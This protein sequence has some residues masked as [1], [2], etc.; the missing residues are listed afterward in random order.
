M[1]KLIF[2][3]LFVLLVGGKAVQAGVIDA[4]HNETNNIACGDCHSYSLWW[5]FSP[6]A[7]DSALQETKVNALCSHCHGENGP[8]VN[9]INH[10]SSAL[11]SLH[12][13]ELGDFSN[14]CINCH[15]PHFQAQL[16][17]KQTVSNE[18]MYLV[19]ADLVAGSLSVIGEGTVASP[20][21]STFLY[22]NLI[23]N[24]SG[25]A[26]AITPWSSKTGAPGRG[27]ILALTTAEP[28][29]TYE[30]I[31]VDQEVGE[32]SVQGKVDSQYNENGGNFGLIYGQLIRDR[33]IANGNLVDVRFFNPKGGFVDT[34]TNMG[35]CQVCHTK[36][37]HFRS[38]GEIN[39]E[40]GVGKIDGYDHTAQIESN[41][42][43]CHSHRNGL[44][45]AGG[46][47]TGCGSATE[48]HGLQDSHVTHVQIG[49]L[50][51]V[52]CDE[53]HNTDNFPYFNDD[54]TIASTTACN[55]C[56]G[57]GAGAVHAKQYWESPG[58]SVRT[59]G[60]WAVVEGEASFCGSCHDD[61]PG[62]SSGNGDGDVAA[63]IMGDQITYGFY[64]TGHGKESGNYE[65]MYYQ[66]QTGS[67]NR[68]AALQVCVTCHG[69]PPLPPS[70]GDPRVTPCSFCHDIATS[71][72]NNP[73]KR[74][75]LEF[76][77]DQNN[78][79][80][81]RCHPPG[82]VAYSE[83]VLYSDSAEFEAGAH[84]VNKCTD[85]HDV[86]GVGGGAVPAMSLGGRRDLCLSCHYA[87]NSQGLPVPGPPVSGHD[88]GSVIACTK[89]HNP[90]K[91]AHGQGATGEG[92]IQCHGHD[93]GYEYSSGKFSQGRGSSFSHS[94]HTENDT[95]D[96]RGPN[97]D[98]ED[99]HDVNNFPYFQRGERTYPD[100]RLGQDVNGDGKYDLSETYVCEDCHSRSGGV[101][102]VTDPQVGAKNNWLEGIY[103]GK[104]LQAGKEMW[105]ASCHDKYPSRMGMTLY[106]PDVY[107]DNTTSGY[108]ASG[109]GRSGAIDCTHCHDP[110]SR[111]I[112]YQQTPITNMVKPGSTELANPTNYR[113]YTGK[114][115]EIPFSKE[116][117][118]QDDFALCY[119]C[120]EAELFNNNDNMT[121]N[122]RD[123]N[124][125]NYLDILAP[126]NL[127]YYHIYAM[128]TPASCVQCHDPHGTGQP[129]M[130]MPG[131]QK[132][133]GSTR[134]GEFVFLYQETDNKFYELTNSD[135]FDDPSIN[136]GFAI[137]VNPSCGVCHGD[138]YT[139]EE[140]AAGFG[141][142]PLIPSGSDWYLRDYYPIPID[143]NFDMDGD[144]IEDDRDNCA[145]IVN[146]DQ[147]DGDGDG[148]GDLCDNCLEKANADQ[149]DGDLDQIGDVC[150]SKPVC[151]KQFDPLIIDQF[152][153]Q[154]A[155]FGNDITVDS[156]GNVTMVGDTYGNLAGSQI[157]GRD[158][159]VRKYNNTGSQLWTRK[160]GTASYEYG[161]GVAV[162]AGGSSFITGKTSGDLEGQQRGLYDVFV[163]KL[164]GAGEQVWT[165]Q[166]GTSENEEGYGV[167]LDSQGS[168]Y[169]AGSTN[170]NLAEDTLGS[171]DAFLRK[172]DV[173]G[174]T[175]WTRQF[176]TAST[177]TIYKVA[178]DGNDR[179][180][181]AGTTRGGEIENSG[182]SGDAFLRQYDSDGNV[183]WT[184]Q[185]GTSTFG[186]ELRG[187]AIDL[188]NNLYVAGTTIGAL[189]GVNQGGADGYIRK[190]DAS[191]TYLW[192]Q[193]LGTNGSDLV[194]GVDVD[195]QGN[196][197]IIGETAGDLAG[198]NQGESD[199]FIGRFD[200]DGNLLWKGQFGTYYEYGS[201]S[202]ESASGI[203]IDSKDNIF[204]TGYSEGHFAGYGSNNNNSKDAFVVKGWA[205]P[206]DF[207]QDDFANID[208]NCSAVAN[209]DQ[210]DIDAD[211]IGDVCD[212]CTVADNS[213]QSDRDYDGIGDQCDLCVND[214]Y[215]DFDNDGVCA[216]LDNCPSVSNDQTDSDFD[217]IGDD[218]D[219][220]PFDE[221]NDQ[222]LDGVCGLADNCPLI[223][224][225][226]QL[227]GDG[228]TV[229]DLCDNCPAVANADQADEDG[230]MVGD[231]CDIDCTETSTW[232]WA[233]QGG[234]DA[235]DY[236]FSLQVDVSGNVYQAG[237]TYGSFNGQAYAGLQDAF[238]VKYDTSGNPLW[239][240]QFGTTKDDDVSDI[241]LDA[242][243]NVYL[244]G[245]TGG[246]LA[247]T[248]QGNNDA[249]VR[250]YDATG[251]ISWTR[252]FG[253][254]SADFGLTIAVDRVNNYVYTA[255]ITQGVMDGAH[256]GN[257]DAYIRKFD[258]D[259]NHIWTRQFG[260]SAADEPKSIAI[261]SVGNIYVV[262]NT[263][264]D[265]FGTKSPNYNADVFV[266]KY[267]ADGIQGWNDHFGN[268]SYNYGNGIAL[269]SSDNV[270]VTGDLYGNLF[271][272]SA[273]SYDAFIRKYNSGG[274]ILW[275]KQYGTSA[276][277]KCLDIALDAND[278]FYIIGNTSGYFSG[279]TSN[280]G[281]NDIF[282]SK[283]NPAGAVLWNKQYGTSGS[284]KGYA[285]SVDSNGNVYAS[286]ESSL[287]F[288]A[289]GT[290][291]THLGSSDAVVL[292][293]GQCP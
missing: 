83:P 75:R 271:G 69:I 41:C 199:L 73:V 189:S 100:Y 57:I 10:S 94:T 112:D 53:C 214:P 220:C 35:I 261:D 283:F 156:N 106:A 81:N 159:F 22:E 59:A 276:L 7:S 48:C 127:H 90:H 222:D 95:D 149:A 33:I 82:T 234:S 139:D 87:G 174:E 116:P 1:R 198:S 161:Y 226:D 246:D 206:F 184:R 37:R 195:S 38:N 190:Y 42:I 84:G 4:P 168:I 166:F 231:I 145:N 209:A 241:A 79:N 215:N 264:G 255:G 142:S 218:C 91:P 207:D 114:S 99:C 172:L 266:V 31:H 196:A 277:D 263:W 92:C 118:L 146:Q 232:T 217:G 13:T 80:C 256:Q 98:C 150:D 102:G 228:D 6:I 167:A 71:H 34:A 152:G 12:R 128:Y 221:S 55:N 180:T 131:E 155:D 250:K 273:G 268:S 289:N 20:Y 243:G 157:G 194:F 197:V 285:V 176:G 177:D 123:P 121:T 125:R 120:H 163:M 171:A 147:A 188:N 30:V 25:W 51:G 54:Q 65:P 17:W 240:R 62:N 49:G 15:D 64:I 186:E 252:Q 236:G 144:T 5:Q 291:C 132:F 103:E 133:E 154:D 173:D 249:Y 248:N 52:D 11:G 223:D 281:S 175:E 148:V 23:I 233:R 56:H 113:F 260:S 202:T 262:G 107:G 284:D 274:N 275:S 162:D 208:D 292:K 96:L 29:A 151:G 9:V 205:C 3:F 213:N 143:N 293:I 137:A 105:C 101:N 40:D 70:L 138:G 290:E 182:Q 97:L 45:H 135:Q 270:Y 237:R 153:S 265:L 192:T 24:D 185:F 288:D 242:T 187:L 211:Q 126:L 66:D 170:G 254:G 111:H 74:L 8:V 44:A 247:G 160:F 134:M 269:D 16:N 89:C 267:S 58:S 212:N 104:T 110:A 119:S 191:G 193:Q 68:A 216:D 18:D 200:A 278:N 245:R 169:V 72:F 43:Q 50:V 60:S 63:N 67:G 21:V 136:K 158:F 279:E 85:C 36:T 61:T 88:Q 229:G 230:D 165:V 238:I 227:D 2:F 14:V 203:A 286:G 86:H 117:I 27:L 129:R 258:F 280:Q 251:A 32:M 259:G 244:T 26:N 253:T 179:I 76:A 109:H 225:V 39:V 204:I 19:N 78:T 178:V 93:E 124:H 77:N 210:A 219:A 257:S 282:V 201:D 130:T 28:N 122:F 46:V 287:D 183:L 181:V 47:G 164:D 140:I 108:Y 224:N 141:P 272:T 235:S 115:M 239:T